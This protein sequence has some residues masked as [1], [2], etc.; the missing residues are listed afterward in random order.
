MRPA[1]FST[2]I[3]ILVLCHLAL[4][5]GPAAATGPAMPPPQAPLDSQPFGV[6]W[7]F[8]YG[9]YGEKPESFLP[10]LR[11][12]GTGFTKVYLF[13]NQLEPKKGEFDWRSVDALLGQLQPGDELLVSVFCSST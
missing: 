7:G 5:A 3:L 13:W 8:L 4:A 11:K 2:L 6:A 9:Y 12:L 1:I 10:Q